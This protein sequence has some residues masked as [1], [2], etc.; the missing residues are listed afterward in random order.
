MFVRNE[1]YIFDAEYG[2]TVECCHSLDIPHNTKIR[3]LVD[4]EYAHEQMYIL[5]DHFFCSVCVSLEIVLSELVNLGGE[6]VDP[7]EG[8]RAV[9]ILFCF[10]LD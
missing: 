6:A 3:L 9:L 8:G 2:L 10:Q 4:N 5:P 7:D 1:V